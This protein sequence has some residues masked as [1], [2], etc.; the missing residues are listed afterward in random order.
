MTTRD[1][2]TLRQILEYNDKVVEIQASSIG[3]EEA[4][5]SNSPKKFTLQRTS[6]MSVLNWN[7]I[8]SNKKLFTCIL[9]LIVTMLSQLVFSYIAFALVD[10][11]ENISIFYFS[12]AL[13][14]VLSYIMP[15][16]LIQDLDEVL[17]NP[18][19][20]LSK[21]I[22][23]YRQLRNCVIAQCLC[24]LVS[25][26]ALV[27][28][29]TKGPFIEMRY[30]M[31]Q[32]IDLPLDMTQFVRILQLISFQ[33]TFIN[34]ILATTSFFL[35]IRKIRYCFNRVE[36]MQ[37]PADLHVMLNTELNRNRYIENFF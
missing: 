21:E 30:N 8:F 36:K 4:F 14:L 9:F 6:V 25:L 29:F 1:F 17:E 31:E 10:I 12:Q 16:T 11:Q 32:G 7:V 23:F 28:V 15:M 3:S 13:N 26:I 37:N 34:L 35:T 5:N 18:F 2:K 33:L 27:K 20:E 24:C 19:A 22:D